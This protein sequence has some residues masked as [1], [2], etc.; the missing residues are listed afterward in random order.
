MSAKFLIFIMDEEAGKPDMSVTSHL[1][2]VL[3]IFY[4]YAR[5]DKKLRDELATHLSGLQRQ[6]LIA[7]W[8]DGEI[9]AG[10]EWNTEIKKHLN[11]SDI[12]LLLISPDFVAS[13]DCY[14]LEMR[15]AL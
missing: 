7:G 8:Y 3:K 6:G 11:L 9:R 14:C 5:R 15:Q 2:K 1:G 10:S 4:S 12:I 13:D